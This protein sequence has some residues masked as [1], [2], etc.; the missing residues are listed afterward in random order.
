MS[1]SMSAAMVASDRP[2]LQGEVAQ[3][4]IIGRPEFKSV[5][6][7]SNVKRDFVR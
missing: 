5:A 4:M 1:E 6:V 7:L 3:A 2:T